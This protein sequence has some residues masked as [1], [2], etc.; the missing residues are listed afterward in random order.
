MA[1]RSHNT[2]EEQ[3]GSN[4]APVTQTDETMNRYKQ[5]PTILPPGIDR[6]EIE[7][8]SS[9][10]IMNSILEYSGLTIEDIRGKS[11]KIEIANTRHFVHYF[12]VVA[13][14]TR[15]NVT[16]NTYRNIA[17]ATIS[18]NNVEN[19][20]ETNKLFRAQAYAIAQLIISN[21]NKSILIKSLKNE[22]NNL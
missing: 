5:R 12:M 20:I 19:W 21:N 1:D 2:K 11:H 15:K 9:E 8:C 22:S 7:K 18:R 6:Q 10:I 17:M 13:G 16:T 14:L 4:P 3:A